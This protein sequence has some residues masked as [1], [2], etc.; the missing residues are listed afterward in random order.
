MSKFYQDRESG[1]A[2]LAALV[3][4]ITVVGAVALKDRKALDNDG[5]TVAV[6]KLKQSLRAANESA[7]NIYKAK[8]I[9]KVHK[10]KKQVVA[11]VVDVAIPKI[12]REDCG[13]GF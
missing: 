11:P 3:V 10:R 12:P 5:K 6:E 4:G 7:L 1:K 2:T 9:D 13:G 8:Y